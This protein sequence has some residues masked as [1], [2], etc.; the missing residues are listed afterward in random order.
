MT[1][2]QTKRILLVDDD[3]LSREVLALLLE[4]EGYEVTA[5]KSG[6]AAIDLVETQAGAA[7][8]A[9]P[10]VILTDMQMPGI[11]G[12]ELRAR[13]AEICG[14]THRASVMAAGASGTAARAS[15]T[16]ILAMSG[17]RPSDAALKNFDGFLLKPFTMEELH[18]AIDGLQAAKQETEAEGL[19]VTAAIHSDVVILDVRTF[20]ELSQRMQK[21]Q[22]SELYGMCLRDSVS[23]VL[24]MDVCARE[25]DEE[26]YRRHAHAMKG[27]LGMVG[28]RELQAMAAEAETYNLRSMLQGP[29]TKDNLLSG[30]KRLRSMLLVRGIEIAAPE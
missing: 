6:Q 12:E 2:Q 30:M 23:H 11:C 5:A 18:R 14:T 25:S 17:T 10:D 24:G 7:V 16:V 1:D 22:V 8:V 21:Q 9:L 15:G 13:L 20:V 29:V 3:E 26:G 19:D 4:A 28:A 27:S